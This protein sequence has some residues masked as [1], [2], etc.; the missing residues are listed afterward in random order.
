MHGLVTPM[1]LVEFEVFQSERKKERK[2]EAGFSNA[3][4]F[5]SLYTVHL[6]YI[7]GLFCG[8]NII[9]RTRTRTL[10]LTLNQTGVLLCSGRSVTSWYIASL[11]SLA[12]E[13]RQRLR[14]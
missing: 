10:T 8:K 2:S 13:G 4:K 14:D 5:I 9:T 12:K 6:S 11:V 1:I 3:I 7:I